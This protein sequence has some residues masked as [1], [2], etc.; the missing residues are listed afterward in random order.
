MILATFLVTMPTKWV[1]RVTSPRHHLGVDEEQP[2]LDTGIAAT[3]E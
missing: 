3:A 2:R 1:E